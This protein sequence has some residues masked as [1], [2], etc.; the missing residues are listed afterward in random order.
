MFFFGFWGDV[1]KGLQMYRKG[2]RWA[3]LGRSNTHFTHLTAIIS[4]TV[5][6][7]VSCQSALKISAVGA[8][9]KT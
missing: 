4:K 8:F 7:S 2:L 6:R 1:F 3:M 5:H 9:K